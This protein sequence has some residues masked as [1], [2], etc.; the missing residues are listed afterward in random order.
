MTGGTWSTTS[1]QTHS[2]WVAVTLPQASW[3]AASLGFSFLL[4][5]YWKLIVL[6]KNKLKKKVISNNTQNHH[7]HQKKKQC[8]FSDSCQCPS[9]PLKA[10]LLFLE[11]NNTPTGTLR[12]DVPANSSSDCSEH[13]QLEM[14][15]VVF[16]GVLKILSVVSMPAVCPLLAKSTRCLRYHLVLWKSHC[17]KIIG[18]AIKPMDFW[19]KHH[20]L[21]L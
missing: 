3:A 9:F 12:K 11:S 14:G 10:A 17:T 7:H 18:F 15:T 13:V 4:N 5:H 19:Q 16:L 21:L 20:Q 2:Q 8:S 1:S 6:Q